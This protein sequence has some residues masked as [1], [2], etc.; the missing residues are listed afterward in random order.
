[1]FTARITGSK[2]LLGVSK[3]VA[4]TLPNQSGYFCSETTRNGKKMTEEL[5]R[6]LVWNEK[7]VRKNNPTRG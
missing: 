1:M 6:C 2:S 4:D 5:G 3:V 7:R